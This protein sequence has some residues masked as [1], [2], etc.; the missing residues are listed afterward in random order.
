MCDTYFTTIYQRLLAVALAVFAP[1]VNAQNFSLEN[2]SLIAASYLIDVKQQSTLTQKAKAL[3]AGGYET[4]KGNKVHFSRWYTPVASELQATWLTQ[5]NRNVGII[6]GFGTGE[7]AEKY[8]ISPSIQIGFTYQTELRKNSFIT[9]TANTS[10]GGAF[11]EKTCTADYGDIGGI[12][13]VNCRLAASTL[14]PEE[15][16]QYLE[17]ARPASSVQVDYKLLF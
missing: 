1:L 17:T 11:K 9:F 14:T 2:H 3:R 16:L 13:E 5:L 12:R 8:S 15:T 4:A 10:L 6:W 7:N